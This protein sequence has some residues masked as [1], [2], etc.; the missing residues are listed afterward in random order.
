MTILMEPTTR[1]AARRSRGF[2][3]IAVYHPKS[4]VNI[5]TLWRQAWLYDAAFIATIGRRYQK[6]SSD[7]PGVANHVPLQ[8]Y[9]DLDDL[10]GHLPYSCPLVGVE[11]DP[12]AKP[13]TAYSH[14]ERACYLL[15]AEDHGLPPAVIDRCHQLV[16]IPGVVPYSMNVAAAGA[17][18]MYDR[19]AKA[20]SRVGAVPA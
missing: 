16:Q 18:V 19:H 10:V 7:T 12:R 3:G 4:E 9:T 1:R 17:I 20:L 6:Q 8:H 11:L 13:L 15:G 14:L 5:G 2:F